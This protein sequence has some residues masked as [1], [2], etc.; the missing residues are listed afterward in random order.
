MLHLQAGVHRTS[1]IRNGQMLGVAEQRTRGT[2]SSGSMQL[3]GEAKLQLFYN[4][5]NNVRPV[6]FAQLVSICE[7][8]Q[9]ARAGVQRKAD[10]DDGR[11]DRHGLRP[12]KI[13]MSNSP[14]GP[15]A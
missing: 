1:V 15:A 2:V 10:A 7:P 5:G 12:A 13:I 8:F 11:A 14:R 6:C 3:L 9:E 4:D